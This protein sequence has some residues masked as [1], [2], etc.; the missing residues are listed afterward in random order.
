MIYRGVLFRPVP[1]ITPFPGLWRGHFRPLW[2]P[3]LE[4]P[5]LAAPLLGLQHCLRALNGPPFPHSWSKPGP[6]PW[7]LTDKQPDPTPGPIP[8]AFRSPTWIYSKWARHWLALGSPTSTKGWLLCSCKCEISLQTRCSL[9]FQTIA[10]SPVASGFAPPG[11][12]TLAAPGAW[13]W[14]GDPRETPCLEGSS[15]GCPVLT[16]AWLKGANPKSSIHCLVHN[17]VTL[18]PANH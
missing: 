16:T 10:R 12:S 8:G 7:L 3:H 15:P 13:R 14:V 2:N 6:T 4:V 9:A 18:S 17:P 11:C 1:P 5:L